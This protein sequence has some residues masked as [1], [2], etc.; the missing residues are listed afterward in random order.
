MVAVAGKIHRRYSIAARLL[1]NFYLM[2]TTDGANTST[3]LCF[4]LTF[5]L[6]IIII[7]VEQNQRPAVPTLT[8]LVI[9][10]SAIIF[11]IFFHYVL[12]YSLLLV[13]PIV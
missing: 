8:H 10:L 5:F 7:N 9:L 1:F 6:V 2:N 3:Q 4:W 12:Q 11:M 13:L